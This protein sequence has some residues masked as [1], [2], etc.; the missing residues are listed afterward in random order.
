MS[1]AHSTDDTRTERSAD[2]T[3]RVGTES[4][5]GDADM[6]AVSDI[7]IVTVER[8]YRGI[9]VRLARHYLEKLGGEVVDTNNIQAESWSATL[10]AETVGVGPTLELTE[11]TVAFTGS[12]DALD[13]LID[14]FSQKAM[15]AGG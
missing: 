1:D 14:R 2:N 3:E 7:D 8:S 11:V 13:T 4:S 9:S 12:Q 15:R 10:S 6:D 5:A